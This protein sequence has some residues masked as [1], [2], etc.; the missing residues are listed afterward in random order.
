MQ[1]SPAEK[2]GHTIEVHSKNQAEDRMSPFGQVMVL[3]NT[4]KWFPGQWT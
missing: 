1:M 4:V 2:R 3:L